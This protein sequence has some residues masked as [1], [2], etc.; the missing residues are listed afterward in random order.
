MAAWLCKAMAGFKC[1]R[2]GKVGLGSSRIEG[3]EWSHRIKRRHRSVRWDPDN[4]DCLCAECHRYY[5]THPVAYI[6]FWRQRG[7]DPEALERRGNEQWDKD[8]GKVLAFLQERVREMK[9]RIE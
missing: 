1:S 5:E 9:E 4:S 7:G 2:C 3:L 6:E 8:Y